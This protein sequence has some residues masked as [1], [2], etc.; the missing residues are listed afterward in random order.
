MDNIIELLIPKASAQ[1]NG[2]AEP[3]FGPIDVDGGS[4][5]A[6]QVLLSSSATGVDNGETFTI[7]VEIRTGTI[8]IDELQVV[9]DY[10]PS[11]LTVIDADGTTNGTQVGF[12][13][14]SFEITN[15]ENDNQVS[16]GRIFVS[17]RSDDGSTQALNANIIDITFQAQNPG[18]TNVEINTGLDGT[19]LIRSSNTVQYTSN[20]VAIQVSGDTGGTSGGGA[21]DG[22][23]GTGTTTDSGN[24]ATGAPTTGGVGTASGGT[25]TGGTTGTTSTPGSTTTG[26]TTIPNTAIDDELS[27]LINLG[28]GTFLLIIGILLFTKVRNRDSGQEH[29]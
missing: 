24:G 14:Q 9:I 1:V 17:A 27:L 19:R 12:S 18:S 5:T 13:S 20:Q 4:S 16:N 7:S 10:D 29:E 26:I 21:V 22:G 6:T 23:T 8:A 25:N 28:V 11:A 2:I 15:A 3:T